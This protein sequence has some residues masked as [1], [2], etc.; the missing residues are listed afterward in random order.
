MLLIQPVRNIHVH[1]YIYISVC[2]C[3]YIYICIYIYVCVYIYMYM[4]VCIYPSHL[5]YCSENGL[6][7]IPRASNC[8]CQTSLCYLMAMK[9]TQMWRFIPSIS[10]LLPSGF[11]QVSLGQADQIQQQ[12]LLLA[13]RSLD[14]VLT[15]WPG[16]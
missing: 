12:L 5:S 11:L 6:A 2:V 14:L 15:I 1:I 7:P 10:G 3:I 9:R 13:P 8:K 16:K 4:C